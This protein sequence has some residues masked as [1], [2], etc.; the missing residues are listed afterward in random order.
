MRVVVDADLAEVLALARRTLDPAGVAALA[1]VETLQGRAEGSLAF[2]R[3]GGQPSHRVELTQVRASGRH[4]RLPWP[5]SVSSGQVRY[6]PDAVSVRGLS[7]TLGRSRVTGASADVALDASG[8][9]RAARGDMVLDLGELYPWL[10]SL[11]GL[12]PA[13]KEV[14]GVTG[15]AA[16]RLARASGTLAHPETLDFEA[17]VE[18]GEVRAVLTELPAPLILAGGKASVTPRAVQLD[19]V[20]AALLDARVTASGRIDDYASPDDRQLDL[21]LAAGAAGAQS[22]DWL[23]TRWKV[24][25]AALPRPPVTLS[26]GRL[27]WSAAESSEHAAQ[28][29]LQLAGDAR[30]EIDL[31][32]GPETLHVRRLALKDADSD[33][34]GSVLWGPS[35]AAFAFAG[36]VDHRSIVR[37][38]ARP[39][40]VL[41]R[42]QGNLRAQIDL[43]APRH[44]TVT[45]TLTGEGLDVLEHWGVPV[46]VERVRIDASGDAVRIHDGI[47][48]V[49]GQ[50]VSVGGGIAVRPEAFAVNL[51]VTADRIDADQVLRAFP[52]ADRDRPSKRS[53]WDIP[54]EGQVAVDAKAIVVAERVVESI[55]GTVRLGP[56][57]ADLELTKASLCGIAVPLNATLTP[58]VATVSGRIVAEG[59]PLATTLPCLLPGP[60]LVVTGRLDADM[61]YAASGPLEEL[62]PRLGGSFR[63]R[64]R[65]GRIQY[66]TLGPKILELGH[67]AERLEAH[68]TAQARTRGLDYREILARGTFDAGRVRLDRF[69]LDARLLGLGLTGEV[70]LEA[71]HLALRGVVAPFG[72]VTGALRRVPVVG[73]LFGARIVGVP[74]SVSG[75][76]HDP[77]VTPLGPE[78]IAGS[79]VDLLGR[80]LNAPIRLLSPLIPSRERAP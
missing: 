37:V 29:T 65:A 69:T 51:R 76:W 74:F 31:S 23:R 72:N 79:F 1:D 80:A 73:R 13:L 47:V 34:I 27:H 55:A 64:G 16:V 58:G 56:K 62:V 40:D 59:A 75:D 57:R 8:T 42:L 38:M 2:E 61:E 46:T 67:V 15:T 70:D 18:P 19:R 54:V 32:W 35:R 6:V 3:R 52:D 49:A 20:G 50:R 11:E 36:R 44:S 45:G 21:T 24:A 26:A 71:G 39:P 48:K 10:A 78:A 7:A 43:A 22:L 63:A 60:D 4:R 66:A 12:R 9:V 17:T 53:V 33:A 68:E 5:V 41:T 28:G 25:P 30:A 14:R 77:R